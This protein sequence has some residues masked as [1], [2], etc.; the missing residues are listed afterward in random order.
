MAHRFH[1]L[2]LGSNIRSKHYVPAMI[3]HWA[4]VFGRVY[5]GPL[6]IT[7]PQGVILDAGWSEPTEI[8]PSF[9]NGCFAVSAPEQ[10][11]DAQWC[12]A[13]SK[14]LETALDR[15]LELPDRR[16]ISRTIDIDYLCSD[17]VAVIHHLNQQEPYSCLGLETLIQYTQPQLLD[18]SP[19]IQPIQYPRAKHIEVA[20]FALASKIHFVW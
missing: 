13:F 19:S 18:A 6:F 20:D 10:W 16:R 8:E 4:R 7:E 5:L 11:I 9:V 3:D 17:D 14:L 1:Y 15:P 2:A 12:M